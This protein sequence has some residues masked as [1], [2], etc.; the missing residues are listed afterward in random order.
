[1]KNKTTTVNLTIEFESENE[2]KELGELY[3]S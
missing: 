3:Y 2:E 1:M